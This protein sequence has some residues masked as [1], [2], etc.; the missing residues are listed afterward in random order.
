VGYR[1]RDQQQADANDNVVR[2]THRSISRHY[3]R[4]LS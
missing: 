2:E 4:I 1:R 3:D